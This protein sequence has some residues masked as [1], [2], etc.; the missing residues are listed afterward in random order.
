MP[1]KL[2]ALLRRNTMIK[3]ISEVLEYFAIASVLISGILLLGLII[4][5][6]TQKVIS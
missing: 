1:L 3:T 5:E 6:I 4:C 2:A